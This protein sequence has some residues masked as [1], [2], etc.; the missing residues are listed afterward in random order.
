MFNYNYL[1]KKNKEA[2][3]YRNKVIKYWEFISLVYCKDHANGEAA[4]TTSKG[5]R[6]MAKEGGSNKD[7]AWSTTTS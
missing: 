1:C 2:K 5:S 4:H 6:E 3:G 7:L